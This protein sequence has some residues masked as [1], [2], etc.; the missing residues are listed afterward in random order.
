VFTPEAVDHYFPRIVDAPGV[1]NGRV[2]LTALF[3]NDF[4]LG[5]LNTVRAVLH[6]ATHP[7]LTAN[8]I[9]E[10]AGNTSTTFALVAAGC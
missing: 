6:R 3:H 5:A 1:G 7:S 9:G 4:G 8:G 10:R 2:Q